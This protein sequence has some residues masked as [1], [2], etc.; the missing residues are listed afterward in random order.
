MTLEDKTKSNTTEFPFFYYKEHHLRKHRKLAVK[1]TCKE[2]FKNKKSDNFSTRD[3]IIGRLK[4]HR[5]RKWKRKRKRK[6]NRNRNQNWNRSRNQKRNQNQN[7]YQNRNR[8][9]TS[10]NWRCFDGVS[11]GI[12]KTWNPETEMET[13]TELEP[14]PD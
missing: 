14:E 9:Q 2:E 12:W 3:E 4:K 5:I 7:Q 13:E 10:K 1:N 6:R 8:S 11:E